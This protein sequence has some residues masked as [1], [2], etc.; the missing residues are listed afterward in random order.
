MQVGI[1]TFPTVIQN[2]EETA[3]LGLVDYKNMEGLQAPLVRLTWTRKA[4][5]EFGSVCIIVD[6]I[7]DYGELETA[8]TVAKIISAIKRIGFKRYNDPASLLDTLT[9][10]LGRH[11]IWDPRQEAL[12]PV[13]SLKESAEE[14]QI[15]SAINGEVLFGVSADDEESAKTKAMKRMADTAATRPESAKELAAW[16][17]APELEKLTGIKGKPPEVTPFLAYA[18]RSAQK[19]AAEA[20]S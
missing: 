13:R 8:E 4:N 15:K 5:K 11:V 7:F 17:V 3:T 6:E 12:V 9:K 20:A 18:R 2:G 1:I 16:A 14:W 10:Q 19:K